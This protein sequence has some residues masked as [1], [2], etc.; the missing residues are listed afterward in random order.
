MTGMD[1][2]MWNI[3]LLRDRRG[4]ETVTFAELADRLEA[5]AASAPGDAYAADRIAAFLAGASVTPPDH[6]SDA[7]PFGE[8]RFA[9]PDAG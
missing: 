3:G 9:D 2:P 6:P 1:R 4:K 7:P 5:Y 8:Q